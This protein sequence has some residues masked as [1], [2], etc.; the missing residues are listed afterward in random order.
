MPR[1]T[2]LPALLFVGGSALSVFGGAAGPRVSIVSPEPGPWVRV[3]EAA[4]IHAA[5]APQAAQTGLPHWRERIQK[6][7]WLILEGDSAL[8]RHFGFRPTGQRVRI[9]SLEDRLHPGADVVWERAVESAVYEAPPEARVFSRER[10]TGAPLAAGFRLG[11]GGVL[12]A[13]VSPGEQ[14]YERLPFLL[15]AA[16]ELGMEPPFRSRRL[17]VFFD[18]SYRLRADPEFLAAR[19]RRMGVRGLHAAAW[20]YV[21][22]DPGRDAWLAGLIDSCHRQGI[23]VYLWLELPHVS[24][25]FWELNPQCREKTAVGQDAKLDWRKLVNLVNPEC[26]GLVVRAVR[27]LAQRFDWDGVNLAELYFESLQGHHNPSRFTPMNVDIRGEFR[28]LAGFDPLELFNSASPLH[29]SR[30]PG[31]LRRF[32]DYRAG[33]AARIQQQWFEELSRWREARPHL[34][35]VVT[36]VDDRLDGAMRD[37]IGSDSA[38]LLRLAKRYGFTFLVE[39]PATVWHLGP[40]RYERLARLYSGGQAKLAHLGVDINVADRYQD[41]YPTKRPAGIEL[42]LLVRQAAREFARVALYS[43]NAIDRREDVWLSSAAAGSPRLRQAKDGLEVDSQAGFGL[44]WQGGALLNGRPWPVTDGETLWI[45]PG[46][47]RLSASSQQL[48]LRL[49]DFSGT[50]LNAAVMSDGVRF[51]YS[52]ESRAFV[53][54][55]RRPERVLINGNVYKPRML[56]NGEGWSLVLPQGTATVELKLGP[57]SDGAGR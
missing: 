43:E 22:P 26:S 37:A 38:V 36:H 21:E 25:Q 53:I 17:W 11:Q 20:H 31:G 3:F 50:L 18:S 39:D 28:T 48:P 46:R 7:E 45:P 51:H 35:M 15:H 19:W 57:A 33:L 24:E 29:F 30:N 55:D 13:A 16:A 10:W 34:D 5:P 32:L 4:G 52:S 9:Q 27:S 56:K 54:L 12:W 8:A 14:G 2:W 47:H 41:V 1:L 42:L 44:H 6:G 23:L 49:L 40:E